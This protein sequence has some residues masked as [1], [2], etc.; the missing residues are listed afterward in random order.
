MDEET[1]ES[2]NT[3]ANST[4]SQ[5]VVKQ[6]A[7]AAAIQGATEKSVVSSETVPEVAPSAAPSSA[8]ATQVEPISSPQSLVSSPSDSGSLQSSATAVPAPVTQVEPISPPQSV[9]SSPSDSESLKSSATAVPAP[10]TAKKI[11]PE[12]LAGL[13]PEFQQRFGTN[14]A[15]KI[16]L[17]GAGAAAGIG[18]AIGLTA[19]GVL[20]SAGEATGSLFGGVVGVA[21]G[22]NGIYSGNKRLE[23]AK[24]HKDKAGRSIAR[25]DIASNSVGLTKG[26]IGIASAGVQFAGV[27]KG[28]ASGLG[29]ATG[30]LTIAEGLFKGGV[31]AMHLHKTRTFKPLS[32]KKGK[33]WRDHIVD[34]K[35]KRVGVNALKVIGGALGVAGSIMSAGILTGVSAA[36]GIGMSALKFGKGLSQRYNMK[37]ER[38]EDKDYKKDDKAISDDNIAK[39][40]ALRGKTSKS[41]GIAGEMIAAINYDEEK[42]KKMRGEHIA[43]LKDPS[44]M[45]KMKDFFNS[46]S[47]DVNENE[48]TKKAEQEQTNAKKDLEAYTDEQK[49]SYDAVEILA[50]IG[51]SPDS[52]KSASGQELIEK[53][54]SVTNSL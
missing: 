8:P 26:A 44:I 47:D 53:K 46:F 37:K 10:A 6:N 3:G 25:Q 45:D 4:D 31:D 49:Q 18:T 12:D 50:A 19:G 38:K 7:T 35:W 5:G 40:N 23:L 41:A 22:I 17:I 16:K 28:V 33:E 54:I 42:H 15:S 30:A 20:K 24:T 13:N 14:T 34:K 39:S 52:A 1:L 2:Q 32:N 43:S 11:S 9:G 48:N 27:A 36:I 29:A 21:Q 51:I